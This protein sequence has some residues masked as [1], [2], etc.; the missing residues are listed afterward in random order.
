MLEADH[1]RKLAD[2]KGGAVLTPGHLDQL[3]TRP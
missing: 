2:R 1:L 3:A